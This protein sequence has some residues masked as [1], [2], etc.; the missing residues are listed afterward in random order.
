MNVPM[1]IIK[2]VNVKQIL[3]TA[4]KK[5]LKENFQKQKM[6]LEQACQQ[7]MFEKRKLMQRSHLSKQSIQRNFAQAIKDREED[8]SLI[9]FKLNQLERLPYGAEI[10]ETEVDAL[11]EVNVGMNWY[12]EVQQ[13]TIVI[14]DGIIVRI[15]HV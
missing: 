5:H 14:K 15:E 12:E 11:V 10:V 7:L 1:K 8:I 13:Q 9:D 4:S 2:K 3:T 6:Q